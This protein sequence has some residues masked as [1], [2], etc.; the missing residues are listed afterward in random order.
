[1]ERRTLGDR[2]LLLLPF[3]LQRREVVERSAVMS[4][5]RVSR[6]SERRVVRADIPQKDPAVDLLEREADGI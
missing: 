5:S 1:M 4:D 2:S 6:P 3:V